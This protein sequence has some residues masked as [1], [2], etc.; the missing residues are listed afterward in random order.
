MSATKEISELIAK[1]LY[2][3]ICELGRKDM[4]ESRH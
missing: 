1:R 2:G 4:I 3:I